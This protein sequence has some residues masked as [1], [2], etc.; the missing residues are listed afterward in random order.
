MTRLLAVAAVLS[1]GVACT[2]GDDLAPVWTPGVTRHANAE[3]LPLDEDDVLVVMGSELGVLRF[4]DPLDPVDDVVWVDDYSA[5]LVLRRDDTAW[6]FGGGATPDTAAWTVPLSPPDWD[7]LDPMPQ[8]TWELRMTSITAQDDL[9]AAT[10]WNDVIFYDLDTFTELG[11]LVLPSFAERVVLHGD[12]AFVGTSAM[13]V[14]VVDISDPTQPVVLSELGRGDAHGIAP[15]G[16]YVWVD[17]NGQAC[18]Y[19][20]TDPAHPFIASEVLATGGELL[21]S[22]N[23]LVTEYAVY[24]V[25]DPTAP[26]LAADVWD[27][28]EWNA[29]VRVG[30][31]LLRSGPNGLLVV[32]DVPWDGWPE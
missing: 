24:D 8:E 21:R 10:T 31:L 18:A 1:L 12:L 2:G 13:G 4:A 23:V 5:S 19:D 6:L 9:A 3:L 11:R 7:G 28:L 30:D 32:F 22:G 29:L 14:L 26:V 17:H 27:G 16:D 25:R 20:L 15:D